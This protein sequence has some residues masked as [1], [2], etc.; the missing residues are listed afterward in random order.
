MFSIDLPI[1]IKMSEDLL[2]LFWLKLF[3][4]EMEVVV[5][6]WPS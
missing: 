3:D 5:L 2:L 4:L 1:I 6:D